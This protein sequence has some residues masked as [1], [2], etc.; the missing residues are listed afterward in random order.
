MVVQDFLN[1]FL[2]VEGRVNI[3]NLQVFEHHCETENIEMLIIDDKNMGL[4][5][6]Y[7]AALLQ[8]ISF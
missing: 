8:L 7:D 4:V 3:F 1:A 5:A 2:S 6:G